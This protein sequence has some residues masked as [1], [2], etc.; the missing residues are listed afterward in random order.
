MGNPAFSLETPHDIH[1]EVFRE[2]LVAM[3][4][5]DVDIS[6]LRFA[7]SVS[8][9]DHADDVVR[10]AV[11]RFRDRADAT[12][13]LQDNIRDLLDLLPRNGDFEVI[14]EL[15]A[16]LLHARQ[17]VPVIF[18]QIIEVLEVVR[19]VELP[20]RVSANAPYVVENLQDFEIGVGFEVADVLDIPFAVCSIGGSG[21]VPLAPEFGD[22]VT[23]TW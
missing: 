13:V 21:V 15:H 16:D 8:S 2:P 19:E 5:D 10:S 11:I 22:A 14:V 9:H 23:A 12:C 1:N 7:A 18:H 20:C 4:E 3:G 17:G 6:G